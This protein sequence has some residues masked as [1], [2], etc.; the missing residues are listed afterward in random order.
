[1]L[2]DATGQYSYVFHA[3]NAAV[4]SGGLFLLVSF[5][6]LNSGTVD[7]RRVAREARDA[8]MAKKKKKP[9]SSSSSSSSGA[10]RGP[11][12]ASAAPPGV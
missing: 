11:T 6:Y 9:S 10:H 12:G 1:M 3:C 5:C 4:T 2:V 8:M 7:G